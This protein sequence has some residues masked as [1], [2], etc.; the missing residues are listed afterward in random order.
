MEIKPTRLL[1]LAEVS[2]RTTLDP[3]T[4]KRLVSKGEFPSP[5]HLSEGRRAWTSASLDAWIA[6]RTGGGAA[7]TATGG[8]E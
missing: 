7:T 8:G 1:K 6:S 4:I 2:A 5:V 3:S